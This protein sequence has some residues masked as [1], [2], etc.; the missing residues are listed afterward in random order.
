MRYFAESQKSIFW[1]E[2]AIFW[3]IG[4]G[5]TALSILLVSLPPAGLER[6]IFIPFQPRSA[7]RVVI[8]LILQ[9]S[10]QLAIAVGGG[11]LVAH[12][13]GLGAPILEAWL[14]NMPIRTHLRG[15]AGPI[16]LTTLLFVVCTT[17]AN[18]SLFHPNRRQDRAIADEFLN[19]PAA[20]K[21]AEEIN[22]LGL[23]GTKP[24]TI[25]SS[26]ISDLAQAV[27]GGI[28]T[29]LF[30]VSV[31]V[32][33]MAQIFGKLKSDARWKLLI[34]AVLVVA[35]FRTIEACLIERENI[36][37]YLSIYQSFGLRH[38]EDATW[39]IAARTGVRV[40][41]TGLALGLVYVYY[42]IE[43]SIA[44]SFCASVASHFFTIIWFTHFS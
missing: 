40:F 19:T 24:I 4:A 16:I 9:D 37:L 43:S 3:G 38:R 44:A 27:D 21:A 17:L 29:R 22:K 13:V 33:L 8:A 28:N 6:Q 31:I 18:S 26:A 5:L 34:A 11:L 39:L 30:A 2:F 36:V 25:I 23:V 14:R 15:V 41:P 7:A 12:Q 42:G 35:A 1:Q 20:E 10:F 32:L